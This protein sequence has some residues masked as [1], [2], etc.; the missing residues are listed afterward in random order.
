MKNLLLKMTMLT[1]L[2]SAQNLFAQFSGGSGAQDDP[3][4]IQ[5]DYLPFLPQLNNRR[6]HLFWYALFWKLILT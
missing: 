2:L 4:L 3:C 1:I 5:I 6:L